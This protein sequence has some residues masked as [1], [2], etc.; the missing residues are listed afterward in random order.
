MRI[1]E[2]YNP[3]SHTMPYFHS[4]VSGLP[5]YPA[6]LTAHIDLSPAK[7]KKKLTSLSL[8]LSLSAHWFSNGFHHP[9]GDVAA[10]ISSDSWRGSGKFSDHCLQ[11][12]TGDV[13]QPLRV[14]EHV[15]T[16]SIDD[17]L[18]LT[19]FDL[20]HQRTETKVTKTRA[21]RIIT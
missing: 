17:D 18:N 12:N 1:D 5:K 11:P 15:G 7:F 9:V 13:S 21:T 4:D 8:S 3:T 20:L 19:V 14:R 6:F 10:G 2:E 16:E